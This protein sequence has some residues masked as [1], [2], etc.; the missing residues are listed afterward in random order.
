MS[1]SRSTTSLSHL[2]MNTVR[3][4]PFSVT[5]CVVTVHVWLVERGKKK[6]KKRGLFRTSRRR[7]SAT[8]R[9]THE[10]CGVQNAVDDASEECCAIEPRVLGHRDEPVGDGF[11]VVNVVFVGVPTNTTNKQSVR[12]SLPPLTRDFNNNQ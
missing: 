12:Q 3:C 6:R 7:T 2:T 9:T 4:L 11:I 10:F 8:K 5:T 1:L